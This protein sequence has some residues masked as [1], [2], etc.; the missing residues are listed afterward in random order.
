MRV[1]QR[2]G[3][4]VLDAMWKGCSS[5]AEVSARRLSPTAVPAA[6]VQDFYV[7]ATMYTTIQ[8]EMGRASSEVLFLLGKRCRKQALLPARCW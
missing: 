6:Y 8:R 4:L 3:G 2:R 1:T 5:D 7:D